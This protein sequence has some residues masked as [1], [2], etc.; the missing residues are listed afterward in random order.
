MQNTVLQ[1]IIHAGN[2]RVAVDDSRTRNRV[3]R[4]VNVATKHC[5]QC[6][7]VAHVDTHH[8]SWQEVEE[9][10]IVT[11]R[12][13]QALKAGTCHAIVWIL[14][15]CRVIIKTVDVLH[16]G[17][18]IRCEAR[19]HAISRQ[20]LI[21]SYSLQDVVEVAKLVFTVGKVVLDGLTCKRI[22]VRLI[23]VLL[24][25]REQSN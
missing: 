1:F 12:V 7:A 17:V 8:L 22:Q 9:C 23:D 19:I 14:R 18:V 24:T 25:T 5:A 11:Q 20:N 4:R 13:G 10:D 21:V 6:H 2:E 3:N 16:D 15:V